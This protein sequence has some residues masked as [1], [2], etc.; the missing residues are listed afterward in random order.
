MVQ[1]SA[2]QCNYVK[3]QSK[4]AFNEKG[5]VTSQNGIIKY[6]LVREKAKENQALISISESF[7][8]KRQ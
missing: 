2:I 4:L 6:I 5:A 8:R 7:P 3:L 1:F